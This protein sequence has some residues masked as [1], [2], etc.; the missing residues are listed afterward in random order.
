MAAD[1]SVTINNNES[2]TD[3]TAVTKEND[4][5]T[6]EIYDLNGR[7]LDNTVPANAAANRKIVIVKKGKSVEKKEF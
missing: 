4:D 7:K 6:S 3:I 1:G 5:N 2:T